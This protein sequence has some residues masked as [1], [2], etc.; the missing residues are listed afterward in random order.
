MLQIT[1][2]ERTALEFLA[3][4]RPIGEIADSLG[5]RVGEVRSRLASLF[6]RMGVSGEAEAVA[7]ASRRG[8]LNSNVP[9]QTPGERGEGPPAT[10]ATL[11]IGVKF[12][13]RDVSAEPSAP[14]RVAEPIADAPGRLSSADSVR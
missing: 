5:V 3:N 13:R 4:G 6:F 2:G 11:Y 10:S 14:A 12:H 7:A 8:L 1:P 9:S